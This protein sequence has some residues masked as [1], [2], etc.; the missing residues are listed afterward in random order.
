M[1]LHLAI[2]KES[3]AR[4]AKLANVTEIGFVELLEFMR[5]QVEQFGSLANVR[6]ATAALN[7]C[8]EDAG[9]IVHSMMPLLV[10]HIADGRTASE[11]VAAVVATYKRDIENVYLSS[12]KDMTLFRKRLLAV[13]SDEQIALKTKAMALVSERS[14]LL[15]KAK[16]ISD[17]R[18]VFGSSKK[19]VDMVEA[20]SIIHTLVLTSMQDGDYVKNFIA[21]DSADLTSLKEIIDRAQAK[22]K[23][24]SKFLESS[25]VSKIVIT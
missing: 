19:T 8:A 11:V 5:A 1:T 18:P 24:L 2:N 16:I 17:V 14:S 20:F 12:S 10:R 4:L 25:K 22:E 9:E 13:L 6:D 21:L 23:S 7:H 3:R 15:H